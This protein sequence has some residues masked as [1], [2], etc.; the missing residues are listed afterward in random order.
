M[1]TI[2]RQLFATAT[3]DADNVANLQFVRRANITAVR[4]NVRSNSETDASAYMSELS[5][6]PSSQSLVNDP[7][8]PILTLTGFNNLV[9]SGMTMNADSD[10]ITG[11]AIP[12]EPGM[13]VYLNFD[14]TGT[15]QIW[16]LAQIYVTTP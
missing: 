5:F 7:N 16:V 8:G 3:A 15:I 10:G 12:V 1:T 11:I 14:V 9:T 6:F 4:M 13:K 2:V